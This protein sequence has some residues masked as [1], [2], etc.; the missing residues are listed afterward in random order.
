MAMVNKPAP[1][2]GASLEET[3]NKEI[4]LT[5]IKWLPMDD[6]TLNNQP[7]KGGHNRKWCGMEMRTERS[8]GGMLVWTGRVIKTKIIV[9]LSN[10]FFPRP[11]SSQPKYIKHSIAAL[12]QLL[13]HRL[14]GPGVGWAD[15]P[16]HCHCKSAMVVLLSNVNPYYSYVNKLGIQ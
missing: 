11:V 5:G 14:L 15:S 7:K 16:M 8:L 13:P 12:H 1:P 6:R 2:P 4:K 3:K 10:Y 9:E